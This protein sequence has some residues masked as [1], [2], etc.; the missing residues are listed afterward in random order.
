[1]EDTTKSLEN[2]NVI[3]TGAG[4]GLG[5]AL[6]LGLSDEGCNVILSGRSLNALD[7]IANHIEVR[8]GRRPPRVALD[9]A[10]VTSVEAAAKQIA[11]D[12]PVIDILVNNGAAWLGGRESPYEAEE[13]LSVVNSAITGTFLFTQALIPALQKSTRPD[14]VTIGSISGLLNVSLYTASV[15]FYAAKH[16]QAALADGLRQMFLGTPIR[17]ICIHPPWIQDMSP[18]DEEWD[19]VPSRTKAEMVTNRDI[20]EAVVYAVT[21]PRHVTIASLVIDSD[22]Q[23]I[24]YRSHR[25]ANG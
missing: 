2:L 1:M 23:G 13:V 14:V 20:L 8:I 3:V 6:S 19:R 17:S 25:A 24:D 21:R 5:A 7:V 11:D 9:L 18:L 22:A 16:G 15:P 12:C 4:R 10:D